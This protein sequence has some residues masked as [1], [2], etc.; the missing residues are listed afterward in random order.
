MG[1]KILLID[2]DLEV[3]SIIRKLLESGGYQVEVCDSGRDAIKALHKY[4]PNLLL[5]DVMLPGI[6]GYSLA[7]QIT[8]NPVTSSLPIIVMSGLE[9]AGSMFKR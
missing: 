8:E 5:L 7:K 3:S 4:K 1:T 9:P 2:D 6:D